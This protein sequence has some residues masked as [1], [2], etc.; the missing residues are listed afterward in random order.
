MVFSGDYVMKRL[1]LMSLHD[2]VL[3]PPATIVLHDGV[4]K[5][6]FFYGTISR[7]VFK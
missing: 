6:H 5:P 3:T 2:M 4:N 1:G 7:S